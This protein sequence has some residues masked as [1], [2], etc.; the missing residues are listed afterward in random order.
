MVLQNAGKSVREVL[1]FIDRF[2]F[3]AVWNRFVYPIHCIFIDLSWMLRQ[4]RAPNPGL[5]VESYGTGTQVRLPGKSAMEPRIFKFGTPYSEMYRSLAATP[6]DEAFFL[7]NG[8]LQLCKR[9]SSV[10]V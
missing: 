2:A 8:V 1:K 6:E 5:T 9:G 7:H 3:I 10:K 4:I